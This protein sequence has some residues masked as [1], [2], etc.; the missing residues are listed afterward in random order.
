MDGGE[1]HKRLYPP[2]QVAPTKQLKNNTYL[3]R[4][5]NPTKLFINDIFFCTY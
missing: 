2:I 1:G 5:P 4:D 3:N